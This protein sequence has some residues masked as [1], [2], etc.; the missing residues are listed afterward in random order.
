MFPKCFQQCSE[1]EIKVSMHL[2]WLLVARTSG[3]ESE[4]EEGS[5]R[6]R[7]KVTLS[8]F[9]FLGIRP[10]NQLS[11]F[12]KVQFVAWRSPGWSGQRKLWLILE[13]FVKESIDWW[14]RLLGCVLSSSQ[15]FPTMFRERNQ[16]VNAFNVVRKW[17]RKSGNK[18]KRNLVRENVPPIFIPTDSHLYSEKSESG[19]WALLP[20]VAASVYISA[21]SLVI[22]TSVNSI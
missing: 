12:R 17:G 14:W 18:T 21:S 4:S 2:M 6:T 16:G 9:Y 11:F 15:M 10:N 3:R 1:R 7:L 19:L 5:P 8:V 20:S 13:V 22:Y